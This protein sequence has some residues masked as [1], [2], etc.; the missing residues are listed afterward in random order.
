MKAVTE[1]YVSGCYPGR[2]QWDRK[3]DSGKVLVIGGSIRYRGAPAL[4]ALAAL[5]AGADIATVAAPESVSD[6]ISSFSPNIIVEPLAGDYLNREDVRRLSVI[7]KRFDSVV[8]GSGLGRMAG[9]RDAVHDFLSG[10]KKPCVIDADALHLVS[11][12]KKLL[13][14]G[15]VI[16]PHAGEFLN[17][18]GHAPGKSVPQRQKLASAFSAEFGATVLLKGYKDVIAEGR[19][20]MVNSTGNPYMTVGGTGDVLAGICGA[21]LAMGMK[22]LDAAACAAFVCGAAGDMAADEKGAGLLAT[23]VIESL[24]EVLKSF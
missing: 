18:S 1:R 11:E 10:L 22:S 2:H 5:R 16:T 12:D 8:I 19:S 13:R 14:K 17:L 21:F 24:P 9:T 3:G 23:D 6:V 7:A 4:C 15:W 20:V